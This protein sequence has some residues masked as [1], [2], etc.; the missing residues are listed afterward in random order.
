MTCMENTAKH[1]FFHGRVQGVGFRY[2]AC[3]VATKHGLT[4]W[5]RNCPDGTVESYMQG[6][7]AAIERCIAEIKDHFGAYIRDVVVTDAA[8]NPRFTDFQITY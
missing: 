3:R 8:F 6:S 5:V 2:T 1:I 4:G 7:P